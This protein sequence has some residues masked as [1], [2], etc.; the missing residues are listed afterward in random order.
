M[1]IVRSKDTVEKVARAMSADKSLRHYGLR[2]DSWSSETDY[3]RAE[4]I[5]SARAAIN[6][7]SDVREALEE[8]RDREMAIA[9]DENLAF[10]V[11]NYS[12]RSAEIIEAALESLSGGGGE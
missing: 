11:R 2:D 6:A 7:M 4:W 9:S 12:R 5:A 1:T 10:G 3:G 8:V